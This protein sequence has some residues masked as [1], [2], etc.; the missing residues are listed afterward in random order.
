MMRYFIKSLFFICFLVFLNSA[1]A[2]KGRIYGEVETRRG[3]KITG[4]IKWGGKEVVW[5]DLF[6]G[7]KEIRYYRT[8]RGDRHRTRNFKKTNTRV[9]FGYIKEIEFVYSN[10][11][12]LKM[13][14]GNT[15]EMEGGY[16][17]DDNIYIIDADFGETELKR[18]NLK[19]V[20]FMQEP[21]DY[22]KNVY[23]RALPLWGE[24]KTRFRETFIGY[25][26]WD[27]D[28]GLATD[29][30]DGKDEENISRKVP[31]GRILSIEPYW[32]NSKIILK[33]DRTFELGGSNDV[34]R[35][36]RG[37]LIRIPDKYQFIINWRDFEKV[38]FIENFK[39]KNYND[40]KPAKRLFGV[41]ESYDGSKHEGYITWDFDEAYT[42]DILD[43][44]YNKNEIKIEFN[45]I[46]MIE[47]NSGSSARITLKSGESLILRGQN[48]VNSENNGI[49]VARTESGEDERIF[50]WDEF[51]KVT[52]K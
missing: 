35:E 23:P 46:K 50:R 11:A 37:I 34:N 45:N 21:A 8:D 3:E 15:I 7:Q 24:V 36:N 43:G 48:D 17:T 2:Q 40:Y 5:D 12:I 33:N 16:N 10:V 13:K 28:E 1:Y 18:R 39:G 19:K 52:F 22:E 42:Y 25:I 26:M 51:D 32:S 4:W 20:T 9:K 29:I 27:K 31:M 44:Y 14:N 41:L 47:Y 49:V 38:T 6:D 30:L